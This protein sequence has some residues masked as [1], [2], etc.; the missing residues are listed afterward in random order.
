M[1]IEH[2]DAMDAAAGDYEERVM[3]LL[4]KLSNKVR[5]RQSDQIGRIFAQWVI[6]YTG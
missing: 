4:S 3:L 1:K 2:T 6:V 5:Q